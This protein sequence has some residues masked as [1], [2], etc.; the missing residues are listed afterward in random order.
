MSDGFEEYFK[1]R[2]RLGEGKRDTAKF[3][4]NHQQKKINELENKRDDFE[5]KWQNTLVRV[6]NL[7]AE[8]KDWRKR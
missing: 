4:W 3:A 1:N 7:E 5:E 8:L 6:S 2:Y